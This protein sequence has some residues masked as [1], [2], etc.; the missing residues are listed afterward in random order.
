[1][2]SIYRKGPLL[3]PDRPFFINVVGLRLSQSD[4]ES[5]PIIKIGQSK[6]TILML[7]IMDQTWKREVMTNMLVNRFATGVRR[8]MFLKRIGIETVIINLDDFLAFIF[9]SVVPFHHL[10]SSDKGIPLLTCD[11]FQTNPA[12]S[13]VKNAATLASLSD[14]K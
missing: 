12:I 11:H 13:F 2:A 6:I 1:M 14:T 9:Q 5:H 8:R 10:Q 7:I 4:H 3:K